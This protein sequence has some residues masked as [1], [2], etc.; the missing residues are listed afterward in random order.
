MRRRCTKKDAPGESHGNLSKN[1]YKLKNS[2]KT[3][4]YVPGG[5]KGDAGTY[6]FKKTRGARIRG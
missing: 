3:M 5:E 6:H 2:D 1:I 4:F